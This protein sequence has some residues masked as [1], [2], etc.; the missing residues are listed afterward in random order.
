MNPNTWSHR[1]QRD[2]FVDLM[3]DVA[4]S[5]LALAVREGYHSV[6]HL[7]RYTTLGMSPDQG[8][9]SN[10]NG[11]TLLGQFTDRSPAAVGTTRFRPP[12]TPVTLGAL[13]GRFRGAPRRRSPPSSPPA[14]SRTAVRGRREDGRAFG[15]AP[16]CLVRAY[17]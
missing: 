1:A 16:P 17:P 12:Y 5:D 6:E 15:V 10:L 13:A 3:S 11:L 4:V 14:D 8:K 7:K 2:A 9:T